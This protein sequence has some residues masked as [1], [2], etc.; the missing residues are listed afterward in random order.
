M[1]APDPSGGT[2]TARGTE[3]IESQVNP[4]RG[5]RMVR[6]FVEMGVV[7][8]V[9]IVLYLTTRAW[10]ENLGAATGPAALL[11]GLWSAKLVRYLFG[12]KGGKAA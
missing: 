4:T 12:D 7:I 11:L 8:G 6:E 5:K 1:T 9:V 2:H 3:A 10:L